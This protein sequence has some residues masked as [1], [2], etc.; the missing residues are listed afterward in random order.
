[1]HGDCLAQSN[2]SPR[3]ALIFV[4]SSTPAARTRIL[5][6]IAVSLALVAAT[7]GVAYWFV[8]ETRGNALPNT[9]VG[10][11]MRIDLPRPLA[12]GRSTSFEIDWAYNLVEQ[13]A[14]GGR[15]GYEHF[16]DD[17]REGGNDIFLVAQWFPRM[18]AYSD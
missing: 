8:T 1:M 10:T 2:L 16:P 18:I 9:I 7:W 14:M 13:K 17:E 15:A 4:E 11:L 3:P 6:Y 5:R 12:P